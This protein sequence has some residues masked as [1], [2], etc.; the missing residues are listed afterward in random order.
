LESAIVTLVTKIGHEPVAIFFLVAFSAKFL[1]VFF[2]DTVLPWIT[3][4]PKKVNLA[5]WMA[6]E[7]KEREERQGTLDS[8]LQELKDSNAAFTSGL[9]TFRAELNEMK[10]LLAANEEYMDN[11]SQG[12]LVQMLRDDKGMESKFRARAFLRLL[13]L[14]VNGR[15]KTS[16]MAFVLEHKDVWLD[17]VEDIKYL[18]LKIKDEA[19]FNKVME[20]INQNIF[21]GTMW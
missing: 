13:A 4:K 3:K 15:I 5:D 19:Y 1:F 7:K 20:E 14:G 6:N 18:K 10:S 21:A 17:A 9:L 2:K 16:G 8:T 11:V 12:T